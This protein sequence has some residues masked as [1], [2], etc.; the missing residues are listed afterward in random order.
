MQKLTITTQI[1]HSR[2][3]LPPV[4]VMLAEVTVGDIKPEPLTEEQKA[5]MIIRAV[6]EIAGI[7]INLLLSST[8]RLRR[9]V[10]ARNLAIH[11]MK[12]HT[13]LSLKKI[14]KA[15]CSGRQVSLDHATIIHSLNCCQDDI[16]SR[17]E[18]EDFI[19]NYE[20]LRDIFTKQFKQ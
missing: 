19:N 8:R 4:H 11:F 6:C 17:T 16:D 14:S 2:L 9:M 15:I 18:K 20:V 12:K 10:M 5:R 3:H 1:A 13:T 7:E